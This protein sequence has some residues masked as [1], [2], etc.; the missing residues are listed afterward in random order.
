L[1]RGEPSPGEADAGTRGECAG[2][3]ALR[4][5]IHRLRPLNDGHVLSAGV[6]WGA[7]DGCKQTAVRKYAASMYPCGLERFS[8]RRSQTMTIDRY[9]EPQ[10]W[11]VRGALLAH[12]SVAF[13]DRL[14]IDDVKTQVTDHH[15][16]EWRGQVSPI[17]M[18][19]R[20]EASPGKADAGNRGVRYG[21]AA[22]RAG[23]LRLWPLNNGRVLSAGVTWIAAA[24][25]RRTAA[26]Q[27]AAIMRS[28]VRSAGRMDGHTQQP[29]IVTQRFG[30]GASAERCTT[31][32]RWTC[33]S[34]AQKRLQIFR[35]IP[36]LSR[37]A[38][39]NRPSIHRR[40]GCSHPSRSS[41]ASHSARSILHLPLRTC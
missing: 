7:D 14:T 23:I 29:T 8:D 32:A 20:G 9:P 5:G 39:R 16:V 1:S 41:R 15:N 3:A 31:A 37:V 25:S 21:N 35:R 36:A 11:V 4:A 6:T 19:S 10:R 24:V 27:F 12:T 13:L 33:S 26:G 17:V 38:R 22:L 18:K 2:D 34:P 30:D 40:F 28:A